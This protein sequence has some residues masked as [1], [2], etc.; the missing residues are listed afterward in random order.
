MRLDFVG[1][2]SIRSDRVSFCIFI[3]EWAFFV[4]AVNICF[5]TRYQCVLC[6]SGM[7]SHGNYYFNYT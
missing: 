6:A 1:S 7:L 2:S 4:F 5:Y 3:L